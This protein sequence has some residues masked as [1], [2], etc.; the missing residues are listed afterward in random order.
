V[1]DKMRLPVWRADLNEATIQQTA[2][3]AKEYGF[4]EEPPSL[5]DLIL[6]D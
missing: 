4:V 6:R 5:D 3:L 2:E 1:T